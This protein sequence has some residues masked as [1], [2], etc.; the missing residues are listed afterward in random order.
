M[1]FDTIVGVEW[2]CERQVCHWQVLATALGTFHEWLPRRKHRSNLESNGLK[3]KH[4]LR[5]AETST[6]LKFYKKQCSNRRS[7]ELKK[8]WKLQGIPVFSAER[9]GITMQNH[10]VINEKRGKTREFWTSGACSHA[11]KGDFTGAISHPPGWLDNGMKP[12]TSWK[13]QLCIKVV[14]RLA[15]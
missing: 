6:K 5:R 8:S 13:I 12:E 10:V 7:K 1:W 2:W 15:G 9:R 3:K 14:P 11:K 4:A